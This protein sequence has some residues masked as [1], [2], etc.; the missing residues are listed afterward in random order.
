MFRI[1]LYVL[2]PSTNQTMRAAALRA[3]TTAPAAPTRAAAPRSRANTTTTAA[4]CSNQSGST[5]SQH[6]SN[7]TN[8]CWYT[9]WISST[10]TNQS[11]STGLQ[12]HMIDA[13]TAG[14][15]GPHL[16]RRFNLMHVHLGLQGRRCTATPSAALTALCPVGIVWSTQHSFPPVWLSLISGE[17]RYIAHPPSCAAKMLGLA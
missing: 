14:M 13:D 9:Y 3:D 5:Q 4:R 10:C 2:P 15:A 8:Q 7:C 1:P 11:I 6:R 12:P 17:S 16:E